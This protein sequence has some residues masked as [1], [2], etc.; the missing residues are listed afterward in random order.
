[1]PG[2]RKRN[3]IRRT[4]YRGI[5]ANEKRDGTISYYVRVSVNGKQTTQKIDGDINEAI[6]L[7]N[8]WKEISRELVL[9]NNSIV[10][11]YFNQNFILRIFKEHKN[12]RRNHEYLIWTLMVL[13]MWCR[14]HA[15]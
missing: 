9:S 5:Y 12:G 15:F 2:Y 6:R 1:M 11:S 14:K 8:E 7:R 3:M 10:K 13:E 4:Q